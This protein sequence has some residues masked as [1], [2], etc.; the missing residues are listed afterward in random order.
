MKFLIFLAYLF[1]RRVSVQQWDG[2]MAHYL[3]KDRRGIAYFTGMRKLYD[4][5][6]RLKR[7]YR[8]RFDDGK[9]EWYPVCFFV[10]AAPWGLK[11]RDC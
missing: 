2:C 11:I 1:R 8:V 5:Q 4:G 10:R 9:W 3:S 7:F 6:Y